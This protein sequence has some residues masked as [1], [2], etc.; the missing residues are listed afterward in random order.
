MP[1]II[2]FP[3]LQCPFVRKMVN[4]R[5]L[6]TNA[7][8]PGYEW[9]FDDGVKVIDKLHGS[10]HCIIIEDKKII[11]IDNR[12]T[13]LMESAELHGNLGKL[14]YRVLQGIIN[15]C[16]KGWF[17]IKKDG[18][19]YG[20]LIGPTMN[21]NL[22]QTDMWYF[23]PFDYLNSSC[24]WKSWIENKYPK[25]FDSISNWFKDLPSLFTKMRMKK[26]G[27]AEGL[28]FLHPDGRR[29]KLRRDMFDWYYAG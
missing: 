19:L 3:K 26:E 12:K 9:I 17:S 14:E 5:Y 16:E 10:N 28:I 21:G 20:E 24:H 15:S 4:D 18:R 6:V 2:D 8:N 13:R 25:N 22:H 11:A 1:D 29:A 23:V 27:I 7:I